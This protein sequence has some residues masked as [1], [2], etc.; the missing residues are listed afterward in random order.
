MQQAKHGLLQTASVVLAYDKSFPS[1][2]TQANAVTVVYTAGYGTGTTDVPES[3]RL[4]IRLLV[5]SYY[6][7]REATSVAK[8]NDLPLGI[9]MLVATNE[10]PEVF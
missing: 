4:A 6:E 8:V 10:V 2:R 9:Q 3:I 7:N 5:G 1:I